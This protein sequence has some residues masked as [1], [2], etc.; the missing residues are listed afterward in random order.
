MESRS[1]AEAPNSLQRM[2]PCSM[3]TP[4]WSHCTCWWTTGGSASALRSRPEPAVWRFSPTPRSS[5]WPSSPSGPASGAR[6]LALRSR[7]PAPLLPEALLPEP[8]QPEGALRGARFA[9]LPACAGSNAVWRFGGLPRPGHHPHPGHREGKGFSQ[10][11]VCRAGHLR[12]EC[13]QDR[14]GLQVLK[15]TLSVSPQGVICAFGA[16]GG[17]LRGEAHGRVPHHRGL[18]RCLPGLLKG[19][20]GVEW[21]RR[22][23]DLYGALV[24]ATPKDNSKRAWAKT[25]RRWASGK[26]QIIEGVIDQ[27]KD[28]FALE[29]H[30]P[31]WRPTYLRAAAQ[32]PAWATAAPPGRPFGLSGYASLV[33][34]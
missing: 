28:L 19:F 4:S 26:R 13:F 22:W 30:R 6:F 1:Y 8:A 25:A 17:L 2:V 5:R 20:T 23:S 15:V 3:S 18:S 12:E 27:P 14:V 16:G 11:A 33:L 29:R 31:R 34:G 7:A 32:R 24:A 9:R 21:E 10:G